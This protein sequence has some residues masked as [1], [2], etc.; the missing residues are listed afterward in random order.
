M[1]LIPKTKSLLLIL[2]NTLLHLL[3]K[4]FL[5]VFHSKFSELLS[6]YCYSCIFADGFEQCWMLMCRWATNKLIF[7]ISDVVKFLHVIEC[8]VSFIHFD[9]FYREF[10]ILVGF[11]SP[12]HLFLIQR[13]YL[14]LVLLLVDF[15]LL[16]YPKFQIFVL[17]HFSIFPLWWKASE[18][19]CLPSFVN[20][21]VSCFPLF[22]LTFDYATPGCLPRCW[23]YILCNIFLI[24]FVLLVSLNRYN[25]CI[26]CIST[27]HGTISLNI[28]YV[29][30]N[31]KQR[32]RETNNT[33]NHR[34]WRGHS[35]IECF[36]SCRSC[37]WEPIYRNIIR[38][39]SP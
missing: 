35:C 26:C 4:F 1:Q 25:R 22:S 20:S 39:C 3:G 12:K 29:L 8:M 16:S 9:V 24:V 19:W 10:V 6:Q 23:T 27:I 7:I 36:L 32:N 28:A 21:S 18:C 31:N 33:N 11:S 2:V 14:F 17:Q 13:T 34:C 37:C 30:L 5:T 38:H 15:I